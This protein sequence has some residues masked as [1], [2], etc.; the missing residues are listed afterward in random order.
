MNQKTNVDRTLCTTVAPDGIY[1]L[2]LILEGTYIPIG[3]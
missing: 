3:I 2:L 1:C